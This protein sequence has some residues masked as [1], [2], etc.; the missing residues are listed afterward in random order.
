[1]PKD[2]SMVKV[3]YEGRTIDGKVFDSSYKN[4]S[5]LSALRANQVIKGLDRSTRSHA[6]R[7]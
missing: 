7:F 3:Q 1:M 6:C 4:V 5:S 2:T